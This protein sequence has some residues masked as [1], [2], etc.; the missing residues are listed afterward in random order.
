MIFMV[1]PI[2]TSSSGFFLEMPISEW[3]TPAQVWP[4][5][6]RTQRWGPSVAAQRGFPRLRRPLQDPP[7]FGNWLSHSYH[8]PIQ[9]I[10]LKKLGQLSPST[11]YT[12]LYPHVYMGIPSELGDFSDTQQVFIPSD[13][14]EVGLRSG[15][16]DDGM[17][18]PRLWAG[19]VQD[20]L[21]MR[22]GC[23]KSFREMPGIH[24][25]DH[26]VGVDLKLLDKNW[27]SLKKTRGNMMN[28]VSSPN[29][30]G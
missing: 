10:P 20:R 5:T 30:H 6:P 12:M 9:L 2:Q 24:R 13:A 27:V 19:G 1:F 7:H 14:S 11:G 4:Q 21:P 15:R 26:E 23:R 3:Q 22:R 29:K 17:W 25:D 18:S 28:H 16:L 8:I